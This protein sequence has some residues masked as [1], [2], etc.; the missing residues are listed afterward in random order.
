[1][2][3]TVAPRKRPSS[4]SSSISCSSNES[5]SRTD[6]GEHPDRLGA[7]EQRHD[8]AAAQAELDEALLL[9]V[10]GIGHVRPVDGLAGAQD[11]LRAPS[12]ARRP[13]SRAGRPRRRRPPPSRSRAPRRRPRARSRSGRTGR[14]PRSSR[15]KALNACSRSSDELSARAQLLAA[16]SRSARRPS[17]SR[18]PSASTAR[19]SARLR[20]AGGGAPPASRR[21]R[22]VIDEHA[23]RERHVVEVERA[24]RRAPAC[25]HSKAA[26]TG[27][28]ASELST[29]PQI[30]V[31]ERRLDDRNERRA[32]RIGVPAS[33][34]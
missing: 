12:R 24:G 25:S 32:C 14:G 8:D 11:L 34:E 21:S 2:F 9:R 16:S 30:A 29:P 20:L 10:G 3:W 28:K 23:D 18:S 7:G 13:G 27:A 4:V 6:D 15:M 26:C 17:S 5:G 31:A 22:P 33:N 19:C 1:M